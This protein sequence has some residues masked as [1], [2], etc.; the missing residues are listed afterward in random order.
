MRLAF[1]VLL[2]PTNAPS[3]HLAS[4]FL[5]FGRLTNAL[6]PKMRMF[7]TSGFLLFHASKGVILPVLDST[8][9]RMYTR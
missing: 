1:C 3:S 7:E 5:T 4:S 8:R 2:I 6:D 9:L